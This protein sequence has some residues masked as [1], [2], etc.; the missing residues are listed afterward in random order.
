MSWGTFFQELRIHFFFGH[1]EARKQASLQKAVKAVADGP[2]VNFLQECEDINEGLAQLENIIENRF[3]REAEIANQLPRGPAV[4][5]EEHFQPNSKTGPYWLAAFQ[6]LVSRHKQSH[7]QWR[8]Y[9]SEVEPKEWVD[10]PPRPTFGWKT[11][12][13][14]DTTKTLFADIT[15]AQKHANTDWKDAVENAQSR[16]DRAIKLRKAKYAELRAKLKV[17]PNL[18]DD[19]AEEVRLSNVL[20]EVFTEIGVK[21]PTLE[22]KN[23]KSVVDQLDHD[24]KFE[25][26]SEDSASSV[27]D[28]YVPLALKE[29]AVS[30]TF[31]DDTVK[32]LVKDSLA[33]TWAVF[34]I[35]VEK[36][37]AER[38]RQT[39]AKIIWRKLNSGKRI[40]LVEI[41]DF[42]KETAL[43]PQLVNGRFR[44]VLDDDG[45]AYVRQARAGELSP[46]GP[47]EWWTWASY[48]NFFRNAWDF[49]LRAFDFFFGNTASENQPAQRSETRPIQSTNIRD[50]YVRR[51]LDWTMLP[52]R[53]INPPR[54]DDSPNSEIQTLDLSLSN[55]EKFEDVLIDFAESVSGGHINTNLSHSRNTAERHALRYE[56]YKEMVELPGCRIILDWLRKL[57]NDTSAGKLNQNKLGLSASVDGSGFIA[58]SIAVPG[59]MAHDRLGDD[60]AAALALSLSHIVKFSVDRDAIGDAGPEILADN[61]YGEA[62]ALH[63]MAHPVAVKGIN[64]LKPKTLRDLTKGMLDYVSLKSTEIIQENP[65]GI[66]APQ[67]TI[68]EAKMALVELSA[69][70]GRVMDRTIPHLVRPSSETGAEDRAFW[71][72]ADPAMPPPDVYRTLSRFFNIAS[73]LLG[74]IFLAVC[75]GPSLTTVTEPNK[76]NL[77]LLPAEFALLSITFAVLCI[78]RILAAYGFSR[79]VHEKT[80]PDLSFLAK[81]TRSYAKIFFHN[82]IF[83][84]LDLALLMAISGI[85]LTTNDLHLDSFLAKSTPGHFTF[86]GVLSTTVWA[87]PAIGVGLISQAI[88]ILS[89]AVTE[90]QEETGE[91]STLERLRWMRNDAESYN[92]QISHIFSAKNEEGKADDEFAYLL[93]RLPNFDKAKL[94]LDRADARVNELITS[95]R[96][97]FTQSSVVTGAVIAFLGGLAPVKQLKPSDPDTVDAEASRTM[98]TQFI[99]NLQPGTDVSG[100]NGIRMAS[101]EPGTVGELVPAASPDFTMFGVENC[102]RP[103]ANTFELQSLAKATDDLG[104]ADFE[105]LQLSYLQALLV[106]CQQAEISRVASLQSAEILKSSQGV[107]EKLQQVLSQMSGFQGSDE[108]I[109]VSVVVDKVTGKDGSEPVEEYVLNKIRGDDGIVALD[110]EVG[111]V[112]SPDDEMSPAKYIETTILDGKGSLPVPVNPTADPEKIAD[113]IVDIRGELNK[114]ENKLVADLLIDLDTALEKLREAI[115]IADV[116]P[117]PTNLAVDVEETIRVLREDLAAVKPKLAIPSALDIGETTK[118]VATI[119][120][121]LDLLEEANR[122]KLA[123][124]FRLKQSVAKF[125]EE[126][127]N[128]LPEAPQIEITAALNLGPTNIRTQLESAIGSDTDVPLG[129]ALTPNPSVPEFINEI[130][131]SLSELPDSEPALDVIV[132]IR[133]PGGI[134]RAIPN[135]QP[136]CRALARFYFDFNTRGEDQ[137]VC[138]EPVS[139]L[140]MK[141]GFHTYDAT[142]LVGF[143]APTLLEKKPISDPLTARNTTIDSLKER[144]ESDFPWAKSKDPRE[145]QQLVVVGYTDST[146]T[147]HVNTQISLERAESVEKLIEDATGTLSRLSTIG[148]GEEARLSDTV[149]GL[150]LENELS[151]RVD[152]L[153]C[154]P[155][156]LR[157]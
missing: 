84:I 148:R 153:H 126:V 90:Q 12:E 17:A 71:E 29:L 118:A 137:I 107:D 51:Y 64:S 36:F 111:E 58:I 49:V 25:Q 54:P 127:V 124:D 151:R 74:L 15:T 105:A 33:S 40:P 20:A 141:S 2:N 75:I 23:F 97:G 116:P 94:A 69:R 37:E 143:C 101:I 42:L 34:R 28:E 73:I 155:E 50:N 13:D 146:G 4:T 95:R 18:A 106:W 1:S 131:K 109:T 150:L 147:A 55:V 14:F 133:A 119:Q 139:N 46:R 22:P 41:P 108:G 30:N 59:D 72:K 78:L 76:F 32:T 8:K 80:E 85:V 19:E 100:W 45:T 129:I 3:L 123:T 9:Q 93:S 91:R 68:F 156:V 89:N 63:A 31:V 132:D 154:A 83:A 35:F 44:V 11:P 38:K 130:K 86:Y 99:E 87:L 114:P 121:E 16:F 120:R 112:K 70:Y 7:S 62:Y 81:L 6:H 113:A 138:A 88:N 125:V 65:F 48:V 142:D 27:I 67:G 140:N 134:G 110:I 103:L 152:V 10:F 102:K 144:I 115:I 104:G 82:P 98:M 61:N 136:Q 117:I 77:N 53:A 96:R 135:A 52:H 79:I 128:D 149:E 24:L 43:K 56:L 47:F 39:D 60:M 21:A 66:V 157:Q 57:Q 122:L 145:T 5:L 26:G 92:A